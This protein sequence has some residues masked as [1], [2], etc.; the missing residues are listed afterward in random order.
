MM[1]LYYIKSGADVWGVPNDS[2]ERFIPQRGEP[3]VAAGKLEHYDEKKHG[4][5]PGAPPFEERKAKAREAREA[6]AAAANR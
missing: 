4:N 3:L 2:V 1:T 6:Q 5:K